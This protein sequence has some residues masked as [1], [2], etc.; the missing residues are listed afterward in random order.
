MGSKPIYVEI[1]I[2]DTCERVWAYSQTPSLHE[3]WDL[4]FSQ[5]T[6]NEKLTEEE[7]QTFTYSTSYVPGLRISGWGE[8]KGTHESA[9]GK[10]TS[11][12]HFGTDQR[13]SPIV[14]G[15]G[16]WKYEPNSTGTT[17]L[18]Q[19]DYLPRFGLLGKVFD[20]AFRPLIGWA[21]AL[22]FDVLKRW[23]ETAEPPAQQYRRFFAYWSV[24]ILFIVVWFYQGWVPKIWQMHPQ[25][26][27]LFQASTGLSTPMAQ[28][29]VLL[30]GII[31]VLIAVLWFFPKLHKPLFSIQLIAFPFLTGMAL[32]ADYKTAFSAFN[33]VTFNLALWVLSIIGFM[34][35]K[36]VPSAKT[37]KRKRSSH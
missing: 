21:T 24:V 26:L 13:L 31:E 11:S 17:F 20:K 3:Q 1:D 36:N 8:S 19:Y 33:V 2:H 12:L 37:C 10:K 32:L 30:L 28:Q 7:N 35:L 23:L 25:E 9:T 4:R 16:Y 14:E 15:K 18:T 29:G 22:S 27:S 5:I 6:Y 34:L